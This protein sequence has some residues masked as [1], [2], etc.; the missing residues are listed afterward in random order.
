MHPNRDHAFG[1]QRPRALPVH[2]VSRSRR[3]SGIGMNVSRD[4]VLVAVLLVIVKF[5]Q[6]T[7]LK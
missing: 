6:M 4:H 2:H 1:V 3:A 7:L 5:V